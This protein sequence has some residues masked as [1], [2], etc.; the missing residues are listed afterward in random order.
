MIINIAQLSV[1]RAQGRPPCSHG[2]DKEEGTRCRSRGGNDVG[3]LR[4]AWE[5]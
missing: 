3:R 1:L 4:G 5:I 2:L